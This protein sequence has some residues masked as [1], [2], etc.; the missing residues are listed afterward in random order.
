MKPVSKTAYYCCRARMLDAQSKRPLC[1]DDFAARFMDQ[2][3]LAAYEPFMADKRALRSNAA[4][5]RIID[6]HLRG[7]LRDDPGLTIVTVGAGFDTRPY[8]LPG[9][10][11]LE[12][13][14]PAVIAVK[15][16]R[17]PVSESPNPLTRLSID[18]Q[19]E[20]L[21]D[22]LAPFQRGSAY[23]FVF[24]G[25]FMY[26][27]QSSIAETLRT[28]RRMFPRH[29][30]I[31]D[32]MLRSFIEKYSGQLHVR[33]EKLGAQI[34]VVDDPSAVFAQSG[35]RRLEVTSIPER[36]LELQLPPWLRFAAR[37][38]LPE[39]VRAGYTVAVFEPVE[40]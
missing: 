32:L 35:Y 27:E 14:E 40:S 9:G 20:R 26:L 11:W 28:L 36:S 31:C 13:D 2:S 1:G 39:E 29:T 37:K 5:H 33:I 10:T 25:V 21:A 17:L 6:D 15:N 16:A 4:R 23:V 12:L 38:L 30:L 8:R 7:A 22:K 24:E 18:F 34:R 3:T 19:G